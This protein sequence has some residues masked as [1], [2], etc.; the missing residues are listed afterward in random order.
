[1]TRPMRVKK[2]YPIMLLSG[3][4]HFAAVLRIRVRRIHMFL[5]QLDPVLLVRGT[6]PAPDPFINKQNS[7]FI[8]T[9]W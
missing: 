8:P 4:S 3:L 1:M 2:A 5:G 7:T 9:V 6:D